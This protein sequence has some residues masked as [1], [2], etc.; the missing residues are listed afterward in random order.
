[1]TPELILQLD[2]DQ[3][4]HCLVPIA[5]FVQGSPGATEI[6]REHVLSRRSKQQ[7]RSREEL[8]NRD[9]LRCPSANALST[10]WKGARQCRPCRPTSRSLLRH[11]AITKSSRSGCSF[12]KGRAC[13]LSHDD[14]DERHKRW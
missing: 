6:V 14:L 9:L 13:T 2:G 5:S 8:R 12:W 3:I 10:A 7:R 4:P 1:L 11:G